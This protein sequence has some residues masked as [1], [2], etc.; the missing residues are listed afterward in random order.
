[1]I[2]DD[3]ELGFELGSNWYQCP[4]NKDPEECTCSTCFFHK[5]MKRGKEQLKTA[6]DR[7]F[8]RDGTVFG[9]MK[10]PEPPPKEQES[11]REK[12][13][14]QKKARYQ[15]TEKSWSEVPKFDLDDALKN[16]ELDGGKSLNIDPVSMAVETV[17]DLIDGAKEFIEKPSL[18]GIAAMA[19][20]AIPGKYA[21]NAGKRLINKVNNDI[22]TLEVK[23]SDMP[24]IASNIDYAILK[25]APSQLNR[26]TSRSQIRK[27]RRAALRGQTSAGSGKSLDEY[28]FASTEQGGNGAFVRSVPAK[29][30]S[31]QGGKMSQFYKKII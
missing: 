21:D 16:P 22:P 24:N 19:V 9:V 8:G 30:Q 11:P 26:V 23:R 5:E 7:N 1:M 25:G 4:L 10:T 3:D 17:V 28:P 13:E 12:Y 27:N 18:S 6:W 2:F 14:R 15:E 31:I 20:T 29:E